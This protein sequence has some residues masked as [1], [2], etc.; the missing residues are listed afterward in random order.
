MVREFVKS[1][2]MSLPALAACFVSCSSH[3]LVYSGAGRGQL[4]NPGQ[5]ALCLPVSKLHIEYIDNTQLRP[6]SQYSDSFL[7]EAATGLLMYEAA[8]LF[9]I[10]QTQP[11]LTDSIEKFQ[12][13]RYSVLAGDTA[14]RLLVSRRV[15]NLAEKYG[16]NIIVMPY[17]ISV[18][19]FIVKP[20]GWRSG[21]GPGYDRPVSYTAKT[22]VHIQFWNS[23]GQLL[24]ER[25]GRSDTGRPIF[26][27]LLKKEKPGGDMVKFAKN[28]FAP[29]LV[30]S[31]YASL[32]T[33]MQINR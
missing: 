20:K 8:Q 1:V 12:A 3:A 22:S 29:P 25:V 13:S 6:E 31:L 7:E 23:R 24:Y 15:Q 30:K 27:S 5:T 14:L 21:N 19:Q 28:F 18:K 17:A 26:Y 9:R 11:D 32:R 16:V 33:A 4:D 10:G 2:L